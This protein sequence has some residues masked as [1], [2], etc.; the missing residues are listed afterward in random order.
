M[1]SSRRRFISQAAGLAATATLPGLGLYAQNA[2]R[3]AQRQ[4]TIGCQNPRTLNPA[5]QSGNVTGMPGAQ[6]FAGL[7][8]MDGDFK[9]V[10]YLA[11]SWDVSDDGKRYRFSL[12]DNAGFHDGRPV[13]ANDVVFSLR[14]VKENH[15]LMSVTYKAILDTVT[16]PDRHTVEIRLKRPFTGLFSLLTPPLTPILPEHIYGDH[17]GPLR[18]NPANDKP[19]GSGPYQF[20]EWERSHQLR[21]TRAKDFF[22]GTPY[23]E[24]LVFSLAEDSLSKSLMLEKGEID[25]LPF[26]FL[27]VADLVRLK[28]NESLVVTPKG[29][30]A[31]GPINYVEFNLRAKPLD[32]IR[33]RQ[34]IAHAIDKN[35]ITQRLHRGMSK[36]LDG[37]FH[38][39]NA[40][41]DEKSLVV[42]DYD[43]DKAKRLLDEAGLKPN[44]QGVRASLTLDVPT[45]EPDST[46]LVADYLKP[47]LRKIG[48]DIVLRKSTDFAD[49]ARRIGAWE[50][51]L[52]MNSTFNWSDPA[53]G[54][55][56][57]F[58]SSNI[59][60]QVWTNT[61][62]Y[63]NDKVDA[64]LAQAAS[65]ADFG[66]RKAI[67]SQ[68]QRQVTSD[69]PFAWTNEGIY[70]TVYNKK[71]THLPMGVFGGL[72]PYDQIRLA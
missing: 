29:Y 58:L 19:I 11:K 50:Y 17:A 15:P 4:L 68:F 46:V 71:L 32:D 47:Q 69:L 62:G 51:Q 12:V 26:S 36:P 70:M 65:E 28:S 8:L 41:F 66:A 44:A 30:E 54:V 52:T 22:R 13:T 18:Q 23:F 60:H 49:W 59:Q 37:P 38:S 7:V 21:M 43:L 56:R 5:V 67:Y 1:H 10:P 2:P 61:E 57:S 9:P 6:L 55:D 40:Y 35:F 20:I 64:W 63:A 14:A 33:V 42:Y 45:F 31:I 25:Y 48:L 53:V 39:K 27:R 72:S 16:A 34:A 3:A 24:Q